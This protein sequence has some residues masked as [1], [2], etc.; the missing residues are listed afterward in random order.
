MSTQREFFDDYVLPVVQLHEG[1][2]V[3]DPDDSGGITN[4]GISLRYLQGLPKS[5]GDINGDGVL[6][7]TDIRRMTK[8]DAGRLYWR[9]FSKSGYGR[10]LL[11]GGEDVCIKLYDTSVNTGPRRAAIILQRA[12]NATLA[13]DRLVDD[14]IIGRRTREATK[15]VLGG[16][17]HVLLAALRAVQAEFYRSIATGRRAKFLDGWLRRAYS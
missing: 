10:W 16:D 12:V 1:G 9:D 5:V 13:D 11:P 2:L 7:A 17:A 4:Y 15:A 3:D 6:D 14:G 8:Q